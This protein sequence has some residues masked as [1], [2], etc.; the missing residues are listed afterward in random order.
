L[1]THTG[2]TEPKTA[3]VSH[4]VFDAMYAIISYGLVS[5]CAAL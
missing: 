4:H 3:N 5:R 1:P 2:L